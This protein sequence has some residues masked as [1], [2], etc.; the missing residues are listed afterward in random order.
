MLLE[1]SLGKIL[2]YS[3]DLELT[4]RSIIKISK[5]AG[6]LIMN[7]ENKKIIVAYFS[8]KGENYS[9]GRI[10]ELKMGNTAIAAQM[11]ADSLNADTF[12]IKAVNEYPFE[13]NACTE[14]AKAELRDNSRPKLAEN[15]DIS[16]YDIVFLGY[17][18][19][20]G[21]MPMVVWT[22]LESHDFRGKIVMPFCT[23]EGSGMGNSER[24]L[25]KLI[26]N[27]DIRK[28]LAIHGS[29]VSKAKST[30]N[31]WLENV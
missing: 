25:K 29:S 9:N 31:H 16:D 23:H 1:F 18:N 26:P 11:I 6:G 5:I 14:E 17:P 3:I 24:D 21:T 13:Y 28:G 4:Q 7:F 2:L 19:W 30:I 22:F 8:H 12:E 10:V 27:A 20:W 15:M